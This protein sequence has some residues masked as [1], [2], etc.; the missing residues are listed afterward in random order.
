MTSMIV[1]KEKKGDQVLEKEEQDEQQP[2]KK[3]S[4]FA[5]ARLAR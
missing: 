1:E 5:L 3:M 2:K 4:K